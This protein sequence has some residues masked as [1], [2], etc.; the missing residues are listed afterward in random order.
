MQDS[1]VGQHI[2]S[3][4]GCSSCCE[5]AFRHIKSIQEALTRG[6]QRH[7]MRFEQMHLGGHLLPPARRGTSLF[8]VLTSHACR[9][10]LTWG[11]G[12]MCC[13]ELGRYFT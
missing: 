10:N 6:L 12:S 1:L 4:T 13:C 11:Q 7:T 2:N 3:M 9:D 8:A 5:A